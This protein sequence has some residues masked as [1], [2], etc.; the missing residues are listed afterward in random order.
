MT[1]H[2]RGDRGRAQQLT[3]PTPLFANATPTDSRTTNAGVLSA[4]PGIMGLAQV[5][6]VDMSV[7]EHLA[8]IDATM[9]QNLTVIAYFKYLVQT[10]VGKGRG[11]RVV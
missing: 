7:P 8:E 2:R 9:M 1:L 6:R 5:E 3:C 11:D 10:L 4:R